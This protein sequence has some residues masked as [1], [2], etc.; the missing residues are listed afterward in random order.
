MELVQNFKL[1]HDS[2]ADVVVLCT[3]EEIR[4]VIAYWFSALPVRTFVAAD[5]YEANRILK[6]TP[7]GLLVTDR[8]LPPWPGLDTFLQLRS[9]NPQLRIACID[10]G[11]L[12]TKI[13]ARMTGATVVLPRPLKRRAVIDALGRP[14]L[15]A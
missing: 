2:A 10:D 15:V 7:R 3:E 4:D 9:R 13:L 14:E 8:V 1:Q 12:D 6:E 5:G 11:T